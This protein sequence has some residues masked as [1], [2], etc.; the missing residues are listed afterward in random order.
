MHTQLRAANNQVTDVVLQNGM[1]RL[2]HGRN[3]LLVAIVEDARREDNNPSGRRMRV[4]K[5]FDL[6]IA[7]AMCFLLYGGGR[8]RKLDQSSTY[9][10]ATIF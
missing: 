5:G 9:K 6:A 10:S 7:S 1:M 3:S 4:A 2:G 8:G